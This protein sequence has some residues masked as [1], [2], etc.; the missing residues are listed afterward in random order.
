MRRPF[1]IVRLRSTRL[2]FVIPQ[3]CTAEAQREEK[4]KLFYLSQKVKL[5]STRP[6]RPSLDKSA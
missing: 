3:R 2:V 5:S 1:K 4:E 6:S